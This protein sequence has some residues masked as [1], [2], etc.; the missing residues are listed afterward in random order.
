MQHRV[1][2]IYAG[3]IFKPFSVYQHHFIRIET[4]SLSWIGQFPLSCTSLIVYHRSVCAPSTI[5]TEMPSHISTCCFTTR[6]QAS[7]SPGQSTIV[8]KKQKLTSK[9]QPSSAVGEWLKET[10]SNHQHTCELPCLEVSLEISPS[11]GSPLSFLPC[12]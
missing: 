2:P 1:S 10:V 7:I 4:K 9:S 3:L 12:L 11:M 6:H 8:Q 5:R